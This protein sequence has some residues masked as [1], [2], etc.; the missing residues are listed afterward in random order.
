MYEFCMILAVCQE[1]ILDGEELTGLSP[2]EIELTREVAEWGFK[3]IGRQRD[4]V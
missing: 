3:F 1:C 2:D 4:F